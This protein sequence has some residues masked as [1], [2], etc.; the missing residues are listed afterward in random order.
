MFKE[1]NR[2]GFYKDSPEPKL[3]KAELLYFGLLASG[4][5]KLQSIPMP[6]VSDEMSF[7]DQ[8]EES[9][10]A[11]LNHDLMLLAD[12]YEQCRRYAGRHESQ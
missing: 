6:S 1:N 7:I 4:A 9:V 8:K 2:E 5:V 10:M 12:L 3:S 11:P